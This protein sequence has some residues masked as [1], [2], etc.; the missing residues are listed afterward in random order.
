LTSGQGIGV[1]FLISTA[2]LWFDSTLWYIFSSKQAALKQAAFRRI[3]I[4]KKAPRDYSRGAAGI[5]TGFV[6]RH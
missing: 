3:V 5:N 4:L 2:N 1:Y 6:D